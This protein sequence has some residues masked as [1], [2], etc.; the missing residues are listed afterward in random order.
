MKTLPF[1]Y[2]AYPGAKP[3]LCELDIDGYVY[4]SHAD[5]VIHRA[6]Y[7]GVFVHLVEMHGEAEPEQG[8][9]ESATATD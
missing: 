4:M 1:H 5:Q 8:T 3:I 6:K 7:R 2:Y 9:H